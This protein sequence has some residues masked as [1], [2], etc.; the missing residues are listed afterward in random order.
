VLTVTGSGDAD[1]VASYQTQKG[2]VHLGVAKVTTPP[3]TIEISGLV[4]EGDL[5]PNVT[6]TDA[7]IIMSGGP[8]DGTVTMSD[9]QGRFRFPAIPLPPWPHADARRAAAERAARGRQRSSPL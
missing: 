5:S 4:H 7:R 1:I 6:V 2:T 9:A 8:A 3:P